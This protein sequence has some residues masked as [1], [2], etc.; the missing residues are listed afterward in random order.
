MDSVQLGGW[1]LK[2]NCKPW[3]ARNR[4]VFNSMVIDL[5]QRIG[6]TTVSFCH[7]DLVPIDRHP[8]AEKDGKN[9]GALLFGLCPSDAL[10]CRCLRHHHAATPLSFITV[11]EKVAEIDCRTSGLK[12]SSCKQ[13]M[14][15]GVTGTDKALDD[16]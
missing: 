4:V 5:G 10:L 7:C 14:V 16:G 1:R 2:R 15:A 13:W 12:I 6:Q 3:P 11:A 9:R 8:A